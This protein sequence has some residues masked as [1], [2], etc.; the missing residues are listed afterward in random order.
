MAGLTA[1]VF[2]WHLDYFRSPGP[3]FHRMVLLFVPALA[4]L[5]WLYAAARRAALWKWE[6]YALAILIAGACLAYEPRATV[7]IVTVFFT[8]SAIGSFAFR[9]LRLKLAGPLERISLSFGAG[10]GLLSVALVVC[11]MLRLFY[12]PIFLAALLL[13]LLLFWREAWQTL[14][15]V[16]ALF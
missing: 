11:G 6:P 1:S 13:P 5:A 7:V 15:D 14:L 12:A 8:C 2:R 4:L 3:Q 10:A 9:C 16:H